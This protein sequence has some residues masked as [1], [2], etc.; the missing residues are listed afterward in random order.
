[1]KICG[2]RLFYSYKIF[3]LDSEWMGLWD[4][5]KVSGATRLVSKVFRFVKIWVMKVFLWSLIFNFPSSFS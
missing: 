1:M 2:Q 5:S 3:V 4:I